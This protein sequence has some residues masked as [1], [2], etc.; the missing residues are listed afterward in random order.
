MKITPKTIIS[1]KAYNDLQDLRKSLLK[2]GYNGRCIIINRVLKNWAH[3]FVFDLKYNKFRDS[4]PKNLNHLVRIMTLFN[5]EKERN[6]EIKRRL[7]VNE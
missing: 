5:S 1:K 4:L 2:S 6:N 7:A 3:T